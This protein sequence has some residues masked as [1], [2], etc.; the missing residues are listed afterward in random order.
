MR[1]LIA[2]LSIAT[3][4]PAAPAVAQSTTDIAQ[5]IR[6]TRLD[7][8][9]T[10]ESTRVPDLAVISAGVVSRATTAS[11]ALQDNASRMDKVIAALK[12]AGI[13]DRD[14]QT[15]SISLNAE[16]RYP[17]NQSPQLTGYTASNQVTIRFHDIRNSGKILDALVAEGANQINGPSMMIEQPEAALDE[18]RTKAIT[19]GRARAELYA[20]S[21]GMHVVRVVSVSESGGSYAPPPPAPPMPMMASAERA[22]TKIEPGEQKLQVTLSMVFELQ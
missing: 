17:D 21:L 3:A 2:A 13:A 12:R 11:A 14:I 15:S 10:G 1:M 16:Y 6:G 22:Y 4:L 19:A 5:A 8:S 18:A 7:L 9:V 20:R